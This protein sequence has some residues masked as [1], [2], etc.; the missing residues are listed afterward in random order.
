MK[1]S[2]TISEAIIG[3]LL[4]GSTVSSLSVGTPNNNN[5]NNNGIRRSDGIANAARADFAN[6][7]LAGLKQRTPGRCPAILL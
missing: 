5:N 6:P 7:A 2:A 4:L 1:F 3:A